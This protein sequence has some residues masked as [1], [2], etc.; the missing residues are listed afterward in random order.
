MS[1]AA[2]ANSAIKALASAAIPP[3]PTGPS[4]LDKAKSAWPGTSIAVIIAA[5]ALFV[6]MFIA[7]FVQ[8]SKLLGSSDTWNDIKQQVSLNSIFIIVGTLAFM[9]ATLLLIKQYPNS[10]QWLPVIIASL[11]LGLSFGA[12]SVAAITR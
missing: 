8:M 9:I 2:T 7:A 1:A 12:L 6:A 10:L 4:V 5:S 11:S 3:T